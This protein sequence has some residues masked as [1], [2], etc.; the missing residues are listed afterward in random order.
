MSDR[1]TYKQ[2]RENLKATKDAQV[3]LQAVLSR[4]YLHLDDLNTAY[5]RSASRPDYYQLIT[6]IA[7]MATFI[8]SLSQEEYGLWAPNIMFWKSVW[9][10]RDDLWFMQSVAFGT[11]INGHLD[12]LKADGCSLD[13]LNLEYVSGLCELTRFSA[14]IVQSKF[15][16][17]Y[18]CSEL[19][20][21]MDRIRNGE[22]LHVTDWQNF[23]ATRNG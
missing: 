23:V 20:A 5:L 1:P 8:D 12:R 13:E 11:H 16:N 15:I 19:E 22:Q 7:Q 10:Y 3:Q 4:R 14:Q 21:L 2:M 17:L 9:N 18:A 6:G